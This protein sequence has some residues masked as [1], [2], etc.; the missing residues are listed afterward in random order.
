MPVDPTKYQPN[1]MSKFEVFSSK[2]KNSGNSKSND[3][4]ERTVIL[5][6]RLFWAAGTVAACVYDMTNPALYGVHPY[7][8]HPSS[9]LC[10]DSN[11]ACNSLWSASTLSVYMVAFNRCVLLIL[12]DSRSD[13]PSHY[14][15]PQ[16][17]LTSRSWM[18]ATKVWPSI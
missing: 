11:K 16:L 2:Y 10:N 4:N 6:K 5:I 18:L 3:H 12:F 9:G 1:V 15:N 13:G 8:P 17:C 7:H 14:F